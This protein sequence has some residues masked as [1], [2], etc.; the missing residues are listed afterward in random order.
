MDFP[1]V[2]VYSDIALEVS[3]VAV[4]GY[5]CPEGIALADQWKGPGMMLY[6][7]GEC[8]QLPIDL[9]VEITD[10]TIADEPEE[11]DLTEDDYDVDEL[12]G[13]PMIPTPSTEATPIIPNVMVEDP[14]APLGDIWP[15]N[16]S[17]FEWSIRDEFDLFD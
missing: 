6:H 10:L 3:G 5:T 8:R 7:Q 17:Q 12:I 9:S 13:Y 4:M 15:A 2:Y 16:A 14:F 1:T 11:M